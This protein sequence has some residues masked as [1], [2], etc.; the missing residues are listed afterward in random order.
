MEDTLA[1]PDA[2]R[3]QVH[4]RRGGTVVRPF[5]ADPQAPERAGRMLAER[6]ARVSA[7]LAAPST[8]DDVRAAA[9]RWQAGEADPL[10]AAAVA[11]I[12]GQG[13][14]GPTAADMWISGHGLRFAALAAVAA[15]TLLIIDDQA[16]RGLSGTPF[17]DPGIRRRRPG[18]PRPEYEP[19]LPGLLRVRAAFA[20][21]S[22][23][24]PTRSSPRWPATG[25][26]TTCTSVPPVRC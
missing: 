16:P 11:V 13:G 1:L 15:A 8:T 22:D 21:A 26:V 17:A 23:P 12:T 24:T 5:A 6:Q 9:T 18:D 7:V 19:A 14:V 4:P 3:R 10:G 2:W 25:P 20:A